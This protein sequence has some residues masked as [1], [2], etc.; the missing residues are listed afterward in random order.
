[1]SEKQAAIAKIDAIITRLDKVIA[2][3]DEKYH[4]LLAE[5]DRYEKMSFWEK[6]MKNDSTTVLKVIID[7]T[8]VNT[9]ERSH[10]VFQ[11]EMIDLRAS[12]SN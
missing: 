3:C 4:T 9:R 6:M 8:E 7:L 12:L 2:E 1:M 11:K 5:I 10:V